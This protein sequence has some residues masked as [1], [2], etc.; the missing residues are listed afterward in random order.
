MSQPRLFRRGERESLRQDD[1]VSTEDGRVLQQEGKAQMTRH[2]RSRPAQGHPN[3]QRLD[4]RK[5]WP[6]IGRTLS[7]CQLLQAR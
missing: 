5:T 7:G 1:E 6:H 2:R 3:N 4:P